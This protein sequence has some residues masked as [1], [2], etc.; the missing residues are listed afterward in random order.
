MTPLRQQLI[1]CMQVRQF[2]PSTQR[3]YIDWVKQ[4]AKAYHRSPDELSDDDLKQFLWSLSIDKHLA[5]GSCYQA[6]YAL[7]FFYQEVLGRVF[8]QRLLPP[9]KRTQKIPELLSPEE[10]RLI[11]TSCKKTKYRTVFSMCYGC[12]MRVGEVL[13]LRVSDIDGPQGIVHI[14][15]GKGRKDR[16]IIIA[17]QLL[18][19]LRKYWRTHPS[20]EYLFYGTE[21]FK[22]LGRS[23][24]QKMYTKVKQQVGIQKRGGIHGLRHAFA[25]HQLSAGMPLVQLQH[26]LGHKSIQT[27][28]RYTHWL[29]NYQ[30]RDGAEFDLI[31][32]LGLSL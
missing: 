6:F 19:I 22:P 20:Q 16:R 25:T 26:M 17:E 4:L 5:G 8:Q 11:I 12:G 28:L 2:A 27:T 30:A 15:Q 3:S 31:G 14:H 7:R 18:H 23:S 32:S 1:H 9:I 29:P 24:V 10:V 21:S 13:A